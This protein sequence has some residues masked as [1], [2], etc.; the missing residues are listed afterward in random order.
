MEV[1]NIQLILLSV[2]ARTSILWEGK[3]MQ[4]ACEGFSEIK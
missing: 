2:W 3:L 1:M 4:L